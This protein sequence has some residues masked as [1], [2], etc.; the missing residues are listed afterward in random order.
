MWP[1][2]ASQRRMALVS[3]AS[4]TG[5]ISPGDALMTLSTSEVAV[6]CSRASLNSQ[7]SA[8]VCVLGPAA[9]RRAA[10]ALRAPPF[11]DPWRFFACRPLPLRRRMASAGVHDNA[12]AYEKA[13]VSA[14]GGPP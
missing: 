9:A 6:C 7:A 2:L 12:Q 5:F 10:V 13:E 8:A 11:V 3:I 4:K 1:N 14:M